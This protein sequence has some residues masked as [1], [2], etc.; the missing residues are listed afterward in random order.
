MIIINI[1]RHISKYIKITEKRL[2][3]KKKIRALGNIKYK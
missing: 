2:Y 1:L 3:S